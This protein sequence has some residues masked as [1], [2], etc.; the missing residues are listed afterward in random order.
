MDGSF[1]HD[2]IKIKTMAQMLQCRPDIP[3]SPPQ[4]T[5]ELDFSAAFGGLR[6]ASSNSPYG[7]YI[8]H[9]KCLASKKHDSISH[10][11]GAVYSNMMELP[12]THG[13]CSERHNIKHECS[14]HKV[15]GNHSSS[16]IIIIQ[17]VK[18]TENQTL[19]IAVA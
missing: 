7:L 4:K 19:K 12:L 11:V 10:P 6:G 8:T 17:V 2:N 1:T 16:K 14:I 18:A 15:P 5:A 13:F 9:Y 3:Q